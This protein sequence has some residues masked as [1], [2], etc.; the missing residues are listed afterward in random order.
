MIDTNTPLK[1][2]AEIGKTLTYRKVFE[3]KPTTSIVV[4]ERRLNEHQTLCLMENGDTAIR[5][6]RYPFPSF[7]EIESDR[8]SMAEAIPSRADAIS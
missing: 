7:A 2:E 1:V 4:K 5:D 8:R 6:S 3:K